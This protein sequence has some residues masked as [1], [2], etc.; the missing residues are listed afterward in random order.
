MLHREIIFGIW[1][2]NLFSNYKNLKGFEFLLWVCC[3]PILKRAQN[4]DGETK[5][6]KISNM[7]TTLSECAARA[8]QCCL[9]LAIPS[10]TIQYPVT[11]WNCTMNPYSH[12]LPSQH[13]T[14]CTK[15]KLEAEDER[16]AN[17]SDLLWFELNTCC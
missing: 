4:V 14:S 3:L 6:E 7:W 12:T 8:R 17:C 11:R 9:L 16:V 2:D 15:E 10:P 1:N 13:A 5:E